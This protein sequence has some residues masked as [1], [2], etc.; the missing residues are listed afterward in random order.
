MEKEKDCQLLTPPPKRQSI[1][2]QSHFNTY[3]LWK[4]KLRENCY[5]RVREDRNRL[6]WKMRLPTPNKSISDKDFIKSAFQNIV[7]DELKKMRHSSLDADLKIPTSAPDP[8]DILWE[9]D[10]LH[11]AYQG[12]C[13]D[14]LLEMQRIFYEDLRAEPT[15]KEP[16]NDIEIW[17]DEEDE[18]LAR[19][20]FENM[21]LNDKLVHKETWCPICK[22]GQLQE[23]YQLIY[24]SLCE[25]QLSKGDEVNL[26]TLPTRLAEVHTEH[27]DRGCRLKPKFSVE[28]RFGL[29]ALYASCEVCKTLEIVM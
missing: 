4:D 14:M 10:G 27:L 16:E 8:S 22:Q 2:T 1:K 6:L 19:A 25:L 5:K 18:Y 12:E 26:E 23:N 28:T 17:E 15:R 24:C 3:P 20:V 11:D 7:S 21:R 29:T 9:Y 13:E